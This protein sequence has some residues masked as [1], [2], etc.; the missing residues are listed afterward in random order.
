M[1]N[2]VKKGCQKR[3]GAKRRGKGAG[4]IYKKGNIFIARW[5]VSLEGGTK[6]FTRSTQTG[7]RAEALKML[8][9]FVAPFRLGSQEKT[10]R[11]QVAEL[12]GVQEKL[13]QMEEQKPA[14]GLLAAWMA[15]RNAPNRPDT[16]ADT[17]EMYESQY[18]RFVTWMQERHPDVKE[19]RKVTEAMAFE[20]ASE[21]G[22]KVSANTYNKYLVLFRRMWKILA[23][24]AGLSAN[25]WLELNNKLLCTHSRR[26]LTVEELTKVC[27]SVTGEMRTLF[28]VGV[29]C[30]LRLGDAARLDWGC[31]DLVRRVVRV[32]PAKTA[33]RAN[34]KVV[35]IPL[36]PSLLAILSDTPPE[37][38]FGRVMPETAAL[39]DHDDRLL[40]KRIK[41]VF[42]ACGIETNCKV[43]GRSKMAVE[44]GFHSLRHSF[45]S[46][47][48]NA[49]ANL[50]AVQAVIGHTNAAMTRHYLHAD[51]E[52]IKQAVA[53]LPNVTGVMTEG[54]LEALAKERLRKAVEALDGLTEEQL[55]AVAEA[56][57]ERQKRLAEQK[58][59]V[60][61][62]DA[63]PLPGAA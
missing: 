28:A 19:V 59:A 49:G 50:A 56:V 30:G 7:N 10:L 38:R 9:E 43:D 33:R 45:V 44:V 40:A 2:S 16:G 4:C 8:E 18:G 3:A 39:Y 51:Q 35:S 5:V 27:G 20:F 55:K 12:T 11:C 60:I 48:A 6:V 1:A 57:G 42:K 63:E 25:P 21:L 41:K 26:E 52:N 62:C 37:R 22:R 13:R 29:Y 61:E 15:Y 17:L 23:K 31:V 14:M 58:Q 32:A 46:L 36:H 24:P 53:L 34:G 47:S 54:E